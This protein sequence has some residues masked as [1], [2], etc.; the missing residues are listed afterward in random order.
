M[1]GEHTHTLSQ[2]IY[3]RER[4]LGSLGIAACLYEMYREASRTGFG[5]DTFGVELCLLTLPI[6]HALLSILSYYVFFQFICSSYPT[7]LLLNI[8]T[9]KRSVILLVV[10]LKIMAPKWYEESFG[11][12]DKRTTAAQ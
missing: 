1:Y 7:L 5:K 9:T 2:V 12:C 11:K 4:C 8:S 6:A 3:Q 10:V